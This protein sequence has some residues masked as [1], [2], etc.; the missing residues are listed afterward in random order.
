MSVRFSPGTPKIT[1]VAVRH[2]NVK[3]REVTGNRLGRNAAQP[4]VPA[5][6]DDLCKGSIL[7]CDSA[8]GSIIVKIIMNPYG[9]DPFTNSASR[10][11]ERINRLT[12]EM[13]W[14]N[15]ITCEVSLYERAVYDL[16]PLENMVREQEAFSRR[17]QELTTPLPE[18]TFRDLSLPDI[19]PPAFT[20]PEITPEDSV[21][22]L[23]DLRIPVDRIEPHLPDFA[24]PKG[25]TLAALQKMSDGEIRDFLDGNPSLIA[26]QLALHELTMRR[27][28]RATRPHWSV[29]WTFWL[30]LISAIS[31]AITV[32]LMLR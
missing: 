20:P 11:M 27:I 26:V 23:N 19:K 31:S 5:C 9:L 24:F 15:R 8:T 12:N 25:C 28:D 2:R 13:D 14:I 7:I 3:L 4:D 29:T 21:R 22:W 17:V 1:A 6:T 10:E 18:F 30:V 32:F 16:S